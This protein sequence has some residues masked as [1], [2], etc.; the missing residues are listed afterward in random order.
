M[1]AAGLVQR[2]A[3]RDLILAEH[4]LATG[5]LAARIAHH[6]GLEPEE[7]VEASL[8]G[9]LHE[10][11]AIIVPAPDLARLGFAAA[12][13][14]L[15]V[16]RAERRAAVALVRAVPE[17]A[18]LADA[19]GSVFD[20]VVPTMTARIVIVA[21]LYDYLVRSVPGR[22]GLSMSEAIDVLERHAGV[23]YDRRAVQALRETDRTALRRQVDRRA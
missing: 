23:R 1:A 18:D 11:G 4:S 9:T 21:D 15:R 22:R 7:I 12:S 10:V 14:V 3:A 5:A 8:I 20:D 6:L 16:Q 2:L 17:I 19:V 13:E